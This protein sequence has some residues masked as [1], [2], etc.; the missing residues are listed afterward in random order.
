MKV[1]LVEDDAEAATY[2]IKGLKESGYTVDHAKDGE[3]GLHIGSTGIYDIMIFDRM[4]PKMDG[5]TVLS[6]LRKKS[7]NTPALILSAL[8]NVDDK[9]KGLRA[10]GD[11]YITKPYSFIE[12]TA[13]L[14]ALSRRNSVNQNQ[15]SMMLKVGDLVMDIRTRKVSRAG[16]N[17]LLQA[18]EFKLLEYLMR[19]AGSVVT[20]TMLLE[21]VWEYNFDPQTNIIDVHIS[22]L[23]QKVDKGFDHSMIVTARGAGYILR[24]EEAKTS[25]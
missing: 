25:S 14:E 22:R 13:R 12:L 15:E 19:N 4:L 5:L 9:V 1:L 20:R 8:G 10:G 11:D 7:I 24:E 17:I 2:L 23:R 3:E 18:R 6:T 21:G 16:K